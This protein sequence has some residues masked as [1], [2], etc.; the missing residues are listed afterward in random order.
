MKEHGMSDFMHSGFGLRR[1]FLYSSLLFIALLFT[2]Y[3]TKSLT[4]E[5]KEKNS[6]GLTYSDIELSLQE[7]TVSYLNKYYKEEIGGGT[8][9][10][11]SSNLINYHLLTENDLVTAQNDYCEEYGLVHRNTSNEIEVQPFIHCYS[12]ETEGYQ[13][14]RLG[15]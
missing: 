10:V 13:G 4:N 11:T 14:W 7:A 2:V 6:K 3:N 8:I 9:T 5:F 1:L 12:Y 15:V